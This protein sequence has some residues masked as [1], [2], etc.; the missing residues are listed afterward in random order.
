MH[1]N[2][3][4][5]IFSFSIA[6]KLTADR[7]WAESGIAELLSQLIHFL[8]I[9]CRKILT[10][11]IAPELSVFMGTCIVIRQQV[12]LRRADIFLTEKSPAPAGTS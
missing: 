1:K 10:R 11:I 5:K 4:V 12:H 8:I 2:L 9:R 3:S 6:E 7:Y